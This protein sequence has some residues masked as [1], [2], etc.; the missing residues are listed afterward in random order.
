MLTSLCR[1]LAPPRCSLSAT[2]SRHFCRA[3]SGTPLYNVAFFGMFVGM[4]LD[5]R[6]RSELFGRARRLRVGVVVVVAVA[7]LLLTSV[8]PQSKTLLRT[9][10][11]SERTTS[12]RTI[13]R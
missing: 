2:R 1:A 11:T 12:L 10:T 9:R 4:A 8:L 7:E 6:S 5:N 13:A 3:R